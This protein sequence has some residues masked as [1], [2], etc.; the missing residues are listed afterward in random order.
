[1]KARLG[2][3]DYY[4]LSMKARELVKSV[5]SPTEMG[6]G[7]WTYLTI[8]ERYQRDL[9]YNRVKNQIAPNFANDNTRFF[10]A[11]IVASEKTSIFSTSASHVSLTLSR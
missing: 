6:I 3:A 9:N 4:I 8:E 1:M 11:V 10:G 5:V 2:D 7:D